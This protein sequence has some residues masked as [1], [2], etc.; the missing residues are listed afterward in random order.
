MEAKQKQWQPC[1]YVQTNYCIPKCC[2]W[3]YWSQE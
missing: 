2:W 3:L 1:V